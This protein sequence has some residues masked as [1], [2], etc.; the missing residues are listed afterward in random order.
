LDLQRRIVDEAIPSGE[1][2]DLLVLSAAYLGV[3][4]AAAL[5]KHA[6]FTQRGLI[7]ARIARA[8]RGH[9]M[10]AQAGRSAADAR[11]AVG[12]MTAV[13]GAEADD[14]GGFASE[15]FNTPLIEGGS[16]IAVSGFLLLAS[17]N[18]AAVALGVLLLQATVVGIAQ[19]RINRLTRWRINALRRANSVIAEQGAGGRSQRSEALGDFRRVYRIVVRLFLLKGGVKAFL[20]FSDTAA[21]AAILGVGGAMAIAGETSLGVIVMFL[22]GLGRIRDPWRALLDYY[23][24]L[25][26]ARVKFALV[27]SAQAADVGADVARFEAD[28]RRERAAARAAGAL[29]RRGRSA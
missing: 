11:G 7:A 27:R 26:D 6:V 15:A 8:I 10:A 17:P 3:A 9:A 23:R 1:T 29:D 5:A 12:S 19:R 24:A 20:K 25:S 4:A 14:L 16:L 22:T 18:L 2:A 13:L 28:A 21:T